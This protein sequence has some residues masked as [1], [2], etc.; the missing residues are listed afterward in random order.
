LDELLAPAIPAP[1]DMNPAAIEID[2]GNIEG[3]QLAK[4]QTGID[5]EPQRG[6]VLRPHRGDQLRRFDGRGNPFASFFG[7]PR[8][9]VV[10]F[11]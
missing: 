6:A 7:S 4:S 8:L 10:R 11:L 2:G 9:P 5:G 1:V 3:Q